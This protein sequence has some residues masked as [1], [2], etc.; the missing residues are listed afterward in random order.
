MVKKNLS[1]GRKTSVTV[2]K[3]TVMVRKTSVRVESNTEV[4][5]NGTEGVAL[6]WIH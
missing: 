5:F 6:Y 2:E 3:T 4:D 1:Q